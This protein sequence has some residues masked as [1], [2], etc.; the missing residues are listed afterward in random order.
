MADGAES[1]DE[2]EFER[3]SHPSDEEPTAERRPRRGRQGLGTVVLASDRVVLMVRTRA[4]RDGTFD[5][6]DFGRFGRV[7]TV[8]RLPEETRLPETGEIV[9][10]CVRIVDIHRIFGPGAA[11]STSSLSQNDRSSISTG[12]VHNASA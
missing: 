12:N 10:L 8:C 6:H 3:R 5:V 2:S 1:R 4:Q 9:R 11:E 7:L